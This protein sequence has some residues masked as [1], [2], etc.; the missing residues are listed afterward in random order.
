VFWS[1]EN[2]APRARKRRPVQPI[3][4]V[5]NAGTA[6]VLAVLVT[7]GPAGAVPPPSHPHAGEYCSTR[8]EP[9]Y[10]QH[11]YACRRASD[12]RYR[13]FA[14]S[15]SGQSGGSAHH[16]D[17]YTTGRTVPFGART[18]TRGC[19]LRHRGALPDRS[20]TPGAYYAKATRA[21]ICRPGWSS[22]VRDVSES[23]KEA[24][25]RE[26]GI[27]AHHEAQYEIDHLVPL[28]DGGS[29]SIAN[30]F[31]EAALPRPGFH[32]KDRLENRTHTQICD[33][34]L[35]LRSTQRRFARNW[36]ELYRFP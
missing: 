22:Q 6:A 20:C 7:A 16:R 12:G 30:L 32:Q 4:Y 2:S 15:G 29:N 14:Y 10:E 21:K 23:T 35:N 24:V 13:L 34:T 27:R 36:I 33:G 31:P 3:G 18:R 26:Y 8:D 11:G 5:T 1:R 17:S 19:H 28:E 9:Y 25:Y